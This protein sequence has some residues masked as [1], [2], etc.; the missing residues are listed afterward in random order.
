MIDRHGGTRREGAPL[1]L[2]PRDKRASESNIH[3]QI[4]SNRLQFPSKL[5]TTQSL[6]NSRLFKS[7]PTSTDRNRPTSNSATQT[8]T[9][10]QQ[11]VR[12]KVLC[13]MPLHLLHLPSPPDLHS[14]PGSPH[15]LARFQAPDPTIQR[16]RCDYQQDECHSL[17]PSL[18]RY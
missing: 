11:Q 15:N 18:C 14:R 10:K 1:P 2:R 12:A 9:Q 6:H 3:R 7:R 8:T 16:P 4:N 17:G 13:T 5:P